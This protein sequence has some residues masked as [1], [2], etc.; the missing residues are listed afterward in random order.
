[1]RSSMRSLLYLDFQKLSGKV[2]FRNNNRCAH[3]N[4]SFDPVNETAI[5]YGALVLTRSP[6]FKSALLSSSKIDVTA[7]ANCFGL[8][9]ESYPC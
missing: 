2:I 6:I 4:L 9:R 7:C 8:C 1:M 3:I 5:F